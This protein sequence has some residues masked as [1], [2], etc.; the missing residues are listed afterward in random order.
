MTILPPGSVLPPPPVWRMASD[1]CLIARKHLQ[2]LELSHVGGRE[3][4]ESELTRI[5]RSYVSGDISLRNAPPAEIPACASLSINNP[6]KKTDISE[7]HIEPA[8]LFQRARA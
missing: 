7:E 3:A 4:Y 6:A 8:L 5:T 2:Q 1:A